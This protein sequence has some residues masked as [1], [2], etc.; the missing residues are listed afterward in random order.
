M[1]SPPTLR[2]FE[3]MSEGSYK[4][5]SGK[6]NGPNKHQRPPAPAFAPSMRGSVDWEMLSSRYRMRG[7][8][9]GEAGV[10]MTWLEINGSA[11]FCALRTKACLI[12]R[13]TGLVG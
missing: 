1:V 6:I 5:K 4:R 2:R 13:N 11:L 3:M 7:L 12:R 10:L 8:R 9:R